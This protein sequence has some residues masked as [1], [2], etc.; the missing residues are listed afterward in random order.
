MTWA[1]LRPRV[2]CLL[3]AILKKLKAV[4]RQCWFSCSWFPR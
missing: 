4:S 2:R 3:T 1:I